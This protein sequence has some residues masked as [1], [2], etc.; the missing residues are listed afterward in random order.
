VLPATVTLQPWH[1]APCGRSQAAATTAGDL[2][3]SC[4]RIRAAAATASVI[5]PPWPPRPAV[6]VRPR[7]RPFVQPAWPISPEL[8]ACMRL[9]VLLDC[10]LLKYNLLVLTPIPHLIQKN[11]R[12]MI[13]RN[14]L[15]QHSTRLN[16]SLV[17]P[18]KRTILTCSTRKTLKISR[19]HL[20]IEGLQPKK[21]IKAR[22]RS[23]H[24]KSSL[25]IGSPSRFVVIFIQFVI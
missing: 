5:S 16:M 25:S 20:N 1:P 24:T 13:L 4:N 22:K 21:S 12:S 15:Y 11:I 7:C 14:Q 8:R 6:V 10:L 18:C 19:E 3:S 2:C 17:D 23:Q 9:D